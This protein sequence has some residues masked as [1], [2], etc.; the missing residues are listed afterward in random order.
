VPDSD[1][2]I[3]YKAKVIATFFNRGDQSIHFLPPSWIIGVGDVSIQSPFAYRYRAEIKG[4]QEEFEDLHV[5]P[6]G[7]F[8]IWV[9]LDRAVAH[10][11]LEKRRG[12]NRLGTLRLPV[13]LGNQEAALEY[14]L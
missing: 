14:R 5:E 2:K 10:E 7:K 3:V 8:S 9:G 11:E 13:R 1:P 12:T 4:H 6:Q